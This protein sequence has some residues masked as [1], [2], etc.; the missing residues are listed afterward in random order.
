MPTIYALHS[1]HLFWALRAMRLAGCACR[2]AYAPPSSAAHH[3]D[4]ASLPGIR[5]GV[6]VVCRGERARV[7]GDVRE[8]ERQRRRGTRS[9]GCMHA[10]GRNVT[11]NM[12]AAYLPVLRC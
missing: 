10:L 7:L 12:T 6:T 11:S 2:P 1:Q 3:A 5:G 9:A 4:P 8:D